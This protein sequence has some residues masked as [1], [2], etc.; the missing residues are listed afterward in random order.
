MASKSSN[1]PA[2]PQRVLIVDDH[3]VFR[4]GLTGL[5]GMEPDLAVCGE[6][7]DACQAM[8]AIA[9][10]NPDL[11]MMDMSLPDKSGLETLKDVRAA[12]PHIPVLMIS[13]HDETL[14]AER[15]IR[16]GGRGYIMKQEGPEKV[17]QA[18][19]KVL[20]GGI[21]VSERISTLILDALA[22]SQHPKQDGAS[23]TKLTDRE[24]EVYRLVGQGK[25]PQE[26]A[27][28]LHLSVKTVD[29]HR[30]QIKKKLGLKNNTELVHH[31]TRWAAEQG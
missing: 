12:Y 10:L 22:S 29:T 20:A 2:A 11:V 6:A 19:R 31:A 4:A 17:I 14:Y 23:V 9:K 21:S 28:L 13:M 25:E 8:A 26:V 7:H 15:V 18:I 24:F 16:A 5:V 1:T 3:P 30:S 27:R